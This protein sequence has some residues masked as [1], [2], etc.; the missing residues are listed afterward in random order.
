MSRKTVD[1]GVSFI[2]FQYLTISLTKRHNAI[3]QLT[4]DAGCKKLSNRMQLSCMQ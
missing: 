3:K 4:Y 1:Y 2:G